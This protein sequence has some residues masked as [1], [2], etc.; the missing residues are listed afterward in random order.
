[1]GSLVAIF[2]VWCI[3]AAPLGWL[4]AYI[5]GRVNQAPRKTLSAVLFSVLLGP[6]GWIILAMRSGLA[7]A[8]TQRANQNV[9]AEAARLVIKQH[10]EPQD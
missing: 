3:F 10:Q 2:F 1:M 8:S 7:Y 6:I 9:T 4:F 5:E